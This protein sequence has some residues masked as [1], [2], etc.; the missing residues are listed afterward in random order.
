MIKLSLNF[1]TET[2]QILEQMS[3]ESHVSKSDI[4]RRSIALMKYALDA[5]KEGKKLGKI[6]ENGE[7]V[8][9]LIGL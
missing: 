8:S 2:N 7:V 9:E 5:K 4:L 6:N 1:S 3:E